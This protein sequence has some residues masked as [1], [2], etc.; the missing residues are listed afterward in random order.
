MATDQP[1]DLSQFHQFLG[2]QIIGGT[3]KSLEDLVDDWRETHPVDDDEDLIADVQ[4]ALDDMEAGDKGTPAEEFLTEL[5]E[6]F[7]LKRNRT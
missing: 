6:R 3:N 7:G 2:E 4:E 5:R 1:N